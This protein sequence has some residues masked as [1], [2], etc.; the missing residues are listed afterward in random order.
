VSASISATSRAPLEPFIR[1]CAPVVAGLDGNR[2]EL[3]DRARLA[4][5]RAAALSM[6]RLRYS[7]YNRAA[8]LLLRR[9][10]DKN[11][12][13]PVCPPYEGAFVPDGGCRLFAFDGRPS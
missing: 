3:C 4:W 2:R 6:L 9:G 1:N 7:H 12:S 11:G 5:D 8:R 13:N 10:E